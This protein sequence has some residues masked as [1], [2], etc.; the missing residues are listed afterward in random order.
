MIVTAESCTGGWVSQ[1]IT[2]ISG[3]SQWFERGFVTYTNLAKQE[4][5][6]VNAHTLEQFGA[7]SEQT[8]KEMAEGALNHSH[9]QISLAITGVAGPSGGTVE[10]PVGLVCFAWAGTQV[11]TRSEIQYFS[12]DRETV[13]RQAVE[14]A[15]NGVFA[16]LPPSQ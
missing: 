10:K 14:H 5:L 16:G 15:L 8:A 1:V 12:G 6:G 7:V 9:A 13:R 4:M 3:S 2:Q 11:A